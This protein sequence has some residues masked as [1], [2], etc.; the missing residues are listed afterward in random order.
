MNAANPRHEAGTASI[1]A[2]SDPSVLVVFG[3]DGDLTKRKLVPAIYNLATQ[4]QLP[5]DFAL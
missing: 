2:P 1:D 5:Q 3:A 4:H